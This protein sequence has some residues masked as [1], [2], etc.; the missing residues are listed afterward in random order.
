MGV[1]PNAP[2]ILNLVPPQTTKAPVA[3]DIPSA[4]SSVVLV[5]QRRNDRDRVWASG[6]SIHIF[7]VVS[8]L[9][10]VDPG[11][12]D[13]RDIVILLVWWG[14]H[15]R[16]WHHSHL[17]KA[18]APPTQ[19]NPQAVPTSSFAIHAYN[20]CGEY[21]MWILVDGWA[22]EGSLRQSGMD[23]RTS[24]QTQIGK[25]NPVD[26]LTMSTADDTRQVAQEIGMKKRSMVEDVDNPLSRNLNA[27]LGGEHAYEL[28]SERDMGGLKASALPQTIVV[29]V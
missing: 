9:S 14:G 7:V 8:F 24:M 1:V 13:F 28:D 11:V 3:T 5:S 6:I 12:S 21:Y 22:D 10:V 17:S 23:I 16:R 26:L 4:L 20:L 25:V 19:L 27:E 15:P 29:E 2:P 18:T